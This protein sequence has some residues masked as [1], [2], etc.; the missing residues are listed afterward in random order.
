[1]HSKKIN[2]ERWLK[3]PYTIMVKALITTKYANLLNY[4]GNVHNCGASPPL[5]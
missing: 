2:G 4:A 3:D 1:M 5:N